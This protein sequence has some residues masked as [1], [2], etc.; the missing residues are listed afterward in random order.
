MDDARLAL[1]RNVKD[2]ELERNGDRFIV[3]GH[4][5][6]Q[7]VLTSDFP[8]ESVM[9]AQRKLDEMRPFLRD[10][11]PIYIVP[12]SMTNQIV[13]FQ[14]HTGVIAIA[15]RK[16]PQSLDQFMQALPARAVLMIL[17][18][19]T[20]LQNMGGLIRVAAA[21]GVNG[22]LVGEESVDPFYRLPIRVSMGNVF[23]LPIIHCKKIADD[24]A[25]LRE[26]WG[27]ELMATVLDEDAEPLQTVKRRERVGLLFGSEGYGLDQKWIDACQRKITIPMSPGTDSLN[28]AVSAAVFLWEMGKA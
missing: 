13:G 6:V 24:L 12:D 25:A 20:S 21:F 2:N 23:R 8:V 15:R 4:F 9:I 18:Q 17:P 26:K 1:Y 14:F 5:V 28:V 16:P 27:V 19:T 10:N 7:R 11:L 22:V 3:E